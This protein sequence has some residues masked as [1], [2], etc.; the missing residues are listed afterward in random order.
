MVPFE[1]PRYT[2]FKKLASGKT[3]F[4]WT[5]PTAYRQAGCPFLSAPLGTNLSPSEL[6]EAAKIWNE[7]LDD[8]REGRFR[9][10]DEVSSRH[11]TVDWLVDAYL[12]HDSFRERVSEFSRPDYKRVLDRV[13]DLEITSDRGVPWRVGAA[14]VQQIG[15]S[16]AEKIYHAFCDQG[17]ARTSEKVVTYCK[18]MWKRMRPHHP[19]QFRPDTPNPWEGVTV[20]RREI[21]VKGYADRATTYRFARAAIANEA[22]ELAAAAIL[23]FEWLLRP[24]NIGAGWAAWTGYRGESQPDK[25]IVRHRKNGEVAIHPLEYVDEVGDVVLLYA[26]A[27]CILSQVPRRGTSIVAKADGTLYGDGTLLSKKVR[28]IADKAGLTSFTLDAA[29]H[30][31]ITELEEAGL[32]EGEGRALSKHRTSS[33]YRRYPK[34]TE[35]KVLNATKKRFGHSEKA[36]KSNKNSGRKV[37]KS[38]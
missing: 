34:E 31:G 16:T 23:A 25:I 6:A 36:E 38:A 26:D 7:R 18:A 30:G 37:G 13:C 32:T 10:D 35:L 8:W 12:K 22:P 19:E 17:A 2:S 14:K 24:S 28:E 3:A 1:L 5:C 21:A 11:G 20:R 15:V 33:A 29:R 4:Y 9:L 27:E